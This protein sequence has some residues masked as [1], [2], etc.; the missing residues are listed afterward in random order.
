MGCHFLLQGI[1]PSQGSNLCLLRFLHGQAGSLPLLPRGKPKPMYT[2][3]Q[4]CRPC[5]WLHHK[6][7][8]RGPAQRPGDASLHTPASPPAWAGDPSVKS[9]DRA[10]TVGE[11]QPSGLTVGVDSSQAAGH[12]HGREATSGGDPGGAQTSV[13]PGV[14]PGRARSHVRLAPAAR[15]PAYQGTHGC[16]ALLVSCR[17]PGFC[18][19]GSQSLL[20]GS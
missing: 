1:F 5:Q 12:S 20:A 19:D 3:H 9:T 17:S 15:S 6:A 8:R 2:M 4:L 11:N 14:D 18:K 7:L 13:S 16:L 10:V